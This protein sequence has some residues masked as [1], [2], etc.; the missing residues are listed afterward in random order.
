MREELEMVYQATL[1]AMQ[2][3]EPAAVATVIAKEGA[4]P[5]EIG[6]KMLILAD[7]RTVGTIGGGAAEAQV[8]TE[9][10]EAMAE[11][12]SREVICAGESQPGTDHS[13]CSEGVRLFIEVIPARSTILIIGAGHVGQAVAEMG[14]SL[15]YRTVVLDQRQE[16]LAQDL[17][18]ATTTQ[19]LG[20]PAEL[21]SS[22][23]V[24]NSTYVVIV[25][26]HNS[27]DEFILAALNELPVAYIGL[28]GSQR[29]TAATFERASEIGLSAA[30][31]E[32]VHTPIG[33]D[34][35]AET[36]REI[37]VSILGEIISLRQ[38]KD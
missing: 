21:L 9:A 11:G 32:R 37:A 12:S 27:P 14:T 2:R 16:L 33:L 1:E 29:R 19:I 30:F 31:L 7:G 5:R 24:D 38:G 34:I 20:D 17:F 8:I 10:K 25:T 18:P 26:P 22:L 6:A 36:P 3:G 23:S 4:G 35:G 15:G 28:M 13:A